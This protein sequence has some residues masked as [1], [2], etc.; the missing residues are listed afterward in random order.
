MAVA[1]PVAEVPVS[2]TSYLTLTPAGGFSS[3]ITA[4]FLWLPPS[5]ERKP[6]IGITIGR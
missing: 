3:A 4:P 5:T 6:V 2:N 1:A